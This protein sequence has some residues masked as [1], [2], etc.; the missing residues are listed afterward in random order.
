MRKC[1]REHLIQAD[2]TVPRSVNYEASIVESSSKGKYK[3]KRRTVNK[4]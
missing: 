4:K 1:S 3:K 2:E